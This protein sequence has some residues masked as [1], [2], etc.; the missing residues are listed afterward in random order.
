MNRHD[1][2][3]AKYK[4]FNNFE[5]AKIYVEKHSL[6]VVVKASGLALGKG[7]TVAQTYEE[8]IETLHKIFIDKIF[9]NAGNEVVIEEFLSG[10]EISIHAFSDGE[11]YQ[12][13]PASQ[14][15]KRIYDGDAG[16][17]TGGMGTIAPLPFVDDVFI[18]RIEREIVAPTIRGMAEE[19]RPFIGILYPGIMLTS[20]GPKVFEFNARFGD[21]EAQS[22]M[23]L[24]KSDLLNLIDASIDGTLDK[25]K[26]EW[27]N[28]S[29]CNI[30]IASAGYPGKYEKGKEIVGIEEA[31][32]NPDIIVFH[33]GTKMAAEKLVTNGGRVL[34]VSAIGKNLE[35][36]LAT[37]YK[38]VSKI[39]FKGMQYRKDIGKK[40]IDKNY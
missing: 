24:L 19:G 35:E 4:T 17:N 11:H 23:R 13:F 40:A 2:P 27:E 6:P 3:T 37:A 29:A 38:A 1:I 8:V 39:K 15:H 5:E 18:K 16:P 34:G 20:E 32:K 10:I 21:P 36:A 28:Y 31:Q 33:A 26:I 14:D 30:A 25:I 12:I 7:V 9:G 22:Y